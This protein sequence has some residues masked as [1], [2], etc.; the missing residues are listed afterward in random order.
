MFTSENVSGI[1]INHHFSNKTCDV[2]EILLGK[3]YNVNN[4]HF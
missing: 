3:A 2:F 4:M 1:E